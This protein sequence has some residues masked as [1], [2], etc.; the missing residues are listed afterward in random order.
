MSTVDLMLLGLLMEKPMNA[1]EMKKVMEFRNVKTWVKISIPSVY[2]NLLTLCKK[3]YLDSKV[4]KEGE[5]PEKTIY[6]INEKGKD[7]FFKLMENYSEEPGM[8]YID[9]MAFTGNIHNIEPQN[10][11]L[12]VKNLQK[13]LALKQEHIKF[14]IDSKKEFIPQHA[15]LMM[16]LY[17]RMYNLFSD[18]C[19]ELCDELKEKNNL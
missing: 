11:Y 9:F 1:Y 5:M 4:V 8:V 7:Y 19:A 2:K 3:G 16:E 18:W 10:G 15:V 14:N 13:A 6:S 12:L 17:A